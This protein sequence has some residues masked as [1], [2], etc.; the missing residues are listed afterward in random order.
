MID[1][2]NKQQGLQEKN[3][4]AYKLSGRPRGT[5]TSQNNGVVID[6]TLDSD[7]ELEPNEVLESDEDLPPN[8][9]PK[10]SNIID[11]TGDSPVVLFRSLRAT[12]IHFR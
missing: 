10:K 6:L 11:L 2:T 8:S 9:P 4:N 12:G 7:E 3:D 1:S 5:R